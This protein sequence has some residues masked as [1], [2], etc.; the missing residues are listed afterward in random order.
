MNI[1]LP[2]PFK[3]LFIYR[4][5]TI[6]HVTPNFI[7]VESKSKIHDEEKRKLVC[8]IEVHHSEADAC[9][10]FTTKDADTHNCK[11][12]LVKTDAGNIF[13]TK[14]AN[15]KHN[16]KHHLVKT[17]AGNISQLLRREIDAAL[18]DRDRT[19]KEAHELREKL[20]I[21]TDEWISIE[22]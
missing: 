12:H 18:L 3:L 16:C 1:S 10:I 8:Q 21:Q 22:L 14:E 11:H 19:I 20:G 5:Q 7:Q 6:H 13:T 9:N 17:N 2:I 15:D 4:T